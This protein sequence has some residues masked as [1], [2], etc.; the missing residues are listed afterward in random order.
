M[1]LFIAIYPKNEARS[2]LFELA[3]PLP[4]K[5]YTPKANIH[6]TL[7]FLGSS[8]ANQDISILENVLTNCCSSNPSFVLE[9]TKLVRVGEMCWAVPAPCEELL[10]LQQSLT[11]LLKAHRNIRTP[12]TLKPFSPHI[13]LGLFK[14]ETKINTQDMKNPVHLKVDEICLMES[15]LT[16]P[17]QQVTYQKLFSRRLL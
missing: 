13:K 7:L 1:R 6:L 4:L 12:K 14:Y 17:K 16:S 8:I 15:S 10:K 11:S 9:F 5:F 2:Q 3:K